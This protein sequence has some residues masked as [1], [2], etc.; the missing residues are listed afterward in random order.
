MVIV[1]YYCYINCVCR[2]DVGQQQ[3]AVD[4]K[5]ISNDY[6][7]YWMSLL[8]IIEGAVA[9]NMYNTDNLDGG[10]FG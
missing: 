3:A 8:I 9:A 4:D 1:D 7:W 5:S 10:Y 6:Y 2:S